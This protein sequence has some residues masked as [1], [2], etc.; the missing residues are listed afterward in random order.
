MG[1]A[2]PQMAAFDNAPIF[3]NIIKQNRLEKNEFGF[4]MENSD[5]KSNSQLILGGVDEN[6]FTGDLTYHKVID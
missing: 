3:D 6:L 2:F 4:F 1:L 5:G